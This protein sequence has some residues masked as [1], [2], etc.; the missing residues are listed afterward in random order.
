MRSIE[1]I[2]SELQTL[3]VSLEPG[4]L[5]REQG[6]SVTR[7]R[8]ELNAANDMPLTPNRAPKR[9]TKT[10]RHQCIGCSGTGLIDTA[11]PRAL[12]R[13]TPAARRTV[14]AQA[15]AAAST[16]PPHTSPRDRSAMAR[17]AGIY[18]LTRD[19]ILEPDVLL[20]APYGE[21][22][23]FALAQIERHSATLTPG[24]QDRIDTLVRTR[25]KSTD[26]RLIA[27]RIAATGSKPY[28]AAFEKGMRH[29]VPALTSKIHPASRS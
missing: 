5:T 25:D 11:D 24:S 10:H 16:T 6:E 15:R 7:L 13:L 27:R 4:N 18:G 28:E 22:R 17:K 2:A 29:K 3:L 9:S 19:S 23:D 14:L 26:G 1:V 8:A 12:A 20:R 21:V